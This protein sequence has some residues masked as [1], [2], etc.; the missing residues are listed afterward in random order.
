MESTHVSMVR[1]TA[2]NVRDAW[3]RGRQMSAVESVEISFNAFY[4]E[5]IESY[6]GSQ[7]F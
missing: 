4:T 6:V 5:Y 2:R 1:A 7:W 3:M